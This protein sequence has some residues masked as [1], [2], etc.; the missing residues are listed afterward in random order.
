[1]KSA[2]VRSA[3]KGVEWWVQRG[4][5]PYSELHEKERLMCVRA[6]KDIRTVQQAQMYLI[7]NFLKPQM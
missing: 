4:R 5:L 6:G 1:M 7:G 2:R 3:G